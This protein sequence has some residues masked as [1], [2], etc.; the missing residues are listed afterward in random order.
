MYMIDSLTAVTAALLRECRRKAGL[1]QADV[2][3]RARTAQSA[4]AAYETAARVPSLGT[5]E[6]LLDACDHEID[7][8]VR[9][10]IRRGATA[11]AELSPTITEDLAAGDEQNAIRRL[12]GFADDFRGSS[13]PGRIALIAVEPALTGAPRFDAALAAIAEFF[14]AE[15]DIDIPGWVNRPARFVEP[16]WFVASRPAVRAHTLANTP[17]AFAR[18]GVLVAAEMLRRV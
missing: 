10:R 9:P 16:G 11:L 12:F 17:A 1:T 8:V 2:A 4:V 18:H 6:R 15:S 14:A 13:R 5:L 3:R 7:I